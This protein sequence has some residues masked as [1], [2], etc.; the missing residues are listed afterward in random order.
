MFLL[1]KLKSLKQSSFLSYEKH[2]DTLEQLAWKLT[3]EIKSTIE[4]VPVIFLRNTINNYENLKKYV[5]E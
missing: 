1:K 2:Q 5:L 4:K 3:D